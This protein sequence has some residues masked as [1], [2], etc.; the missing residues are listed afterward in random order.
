MTYDFAKIRHRC[1]GATFQRACD[2][3]REGKVM[4]VRRF[5]KTCEAT[6]TGNHAYQVIVDTEKFGY[7]DC[8]CYIGENGGLC[9]H[10]VALSI[11]VA[12]DG[13]EITAGDLEMANQPLFSGQLGE[14]DSEEIARYKITISSAMKLIKPY[15]GPS[16]IWFRYQ[17]DIDEACTIIE[18]EVSKVPVS[19]SSAKLLVN[20]LLRLE[21]K[22]IH[23]VDDSNGTVGGCMS[24]IVEVLIEFVKAD[25]DCIKE[26]A[27]LCDL[28][29]SF[30]WEEPLV[31]E[32]DNQE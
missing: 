28:R 13:A 4:R 14:L 8:D 22:L 19:R 15:S 10:L 24:S 12:L 17:N 25:R 20:L 30:G 23:G 21:R 5:G 31:A 3:Y 27:K 29:T 16:R 7:G 2:I 6:V 9:K 11:Y 26:F 18:E 1:Y 32:L